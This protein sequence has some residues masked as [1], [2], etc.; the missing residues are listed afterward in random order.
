MRCAT[1]HI[2]L[3]WSS[4][5]YLYA[6]VQSVCCADEFEI[7]CQAA[8]VLSNAMVAKTAKSIQCQVRL[9]TKGIRGSI[10][11]VCL[12]CDV[13]SLLRLFLFSSTGVHWPSQHSLTL[14][15][16]S[17][18]SVLCV[19]A[20]F[21]S[22]LRRCASFCLLLSFVS[23]GMHCMR[24]S[25]QHSLTLVVSSQVSALCVLAWFASYLRR[26]ASFCLLLSFVSTDVQYCVLFCFHSFHGAPLFPIGSGMPLTL[27]S[28][29]KL[30]K[31]YLMYS[32][33]APGV[34][35]PTTLLRLLL[36]SSAFVLL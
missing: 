34:F 4:R 5:I 2:E 27:G 21:A 23:T 17:Q 16:S 22:S 32:G 30:P 26:C 10:I 33:V 11:C 15:V 8:L 13:S 24:G 25:S 19:L 28:Q 6:R 9:S 12:V 29:S 20:W 7:W 31:Q 3:F 18:V 36:I 14:V 1:R 35:L